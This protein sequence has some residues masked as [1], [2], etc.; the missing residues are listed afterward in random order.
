MSGGPN[1][2]RGSRAAGRLRRLLQA[3][4]HLFGTRLMTAGNAILYEFPE[5]EGRAP[6]PPIPEPRES[7]RVLCFSPYAMWGIHS[8]WEITVLRA[9]ERRGCETRLVFCD[10]A[11]PMCDL[12]W[13]RNERP[14]DR[15]LVC[16]N[17]TT[18]H[19]RI[20]RHPFEWL[21]RSLEP[22]EREEATRW[23]ASLPEDGLRSAEFRGKP[24]GSWCEGSMFSHFRLSR[25]DLDADPRFR[26]VYR[27]YL[28]GAAVTLLACQR[29]IDTMRPDV[30][31]L[32][33]G[34]MSLPRVAF[35]VARERGIR[36]VCHERGAVYNSLLLWEN[37]RCCDYQGLRASALR[38]ADRP[39]SPSQAKAAVRWVTDR[40]AGKNLGTVSFA[41]PRRRSKSTLAAAGLEPGDRF[42]AVLTSSD[43]EF[44][45][46]GNRNRVFA[47]QHEWVA[48][49]IDWASASADR[50]VVVRFHPNTSKASWEYNAARLGRGLTG[51]D[52]EGIRRVSDRVC[53]VPP[54]SRIDTYAFIDAC[55]LATTYGSTTGIEAAAL[56]KPVIVADECRYHGMPWVR[57]AETPDH[58]L[59]LL[60][61]AFEGGESADEI[62]IA[63]GAL[64]YAW[65]GFQGASVTS[66]RIR[67]PGVHRGRVAYRADIPSQLDYGK[68]AGIDRITD[69]ILGKRPLHEP[70][71]PADGAAERAIVLSYLRRF[72]TRRRQAGR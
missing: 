2:G 44:V 60:D 35:E 21:S 53:V 67:R 8:T 40:R 62:A 33:N 9:L 48:A 27:Q 50:K 51:R 19:A 30:L 36:V 70:R 45:S 63:T 24:L 39:L 20:M 10:A 41:P 34:R 23:A 32:F 1:A 55:T 68:D 3:P 37:E 12:F 46:A 43:D 65:D 13:E 29:L 31:W 5:R 18:L 4:G 72:A 66:R 11:S 26:V 54:K 15:C 38:N 71:P 58:F 59:G 17:R 57:S 69:I 28:E 25:L 47:E 6:D 7:Q 64:R 22:R 61:E 56:G 14:F 49:V 42:V 16:Q 52:V